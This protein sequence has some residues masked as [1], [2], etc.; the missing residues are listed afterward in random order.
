M[1]GKISKYLK[2]TDYKPNGNSP[3]GEAEQMLA[4][5]T[6]KQ[7]LGREAQAALL[8]VRIWPECPERNLS[9]LTLASKPDCGI[10]TMQKASPNLRH[11]QACAQKKELNRDSQLQTIPLRRQAARA[12]RRQMQPQRDI[13]YKTVSRLLC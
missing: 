5:A 1:G 6:S 9:E 3:S 7:G 4:P 8:R 10:T 11:R 2:P 13:I 12:G